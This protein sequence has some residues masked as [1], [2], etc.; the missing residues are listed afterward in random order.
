[1]STQGFS[2]MAP[3]RK[4][5]TLSDDLINEILVRLPVKSLVR[6]ESVSK[7]WLSLIKDPAFVNSQLLRAMTIETD[8]TLFVKR[9]SRNNHFAVLHVDSRQIVADLELP[10]PHGNVWRKVADPIDVPF[11]DFHVCVNGFLVGIGQ[12]DMMAFD[13]NKEV[14]NCAIKLPFISDEDDGEDNARVIEYNK[15][16]SV[17]TLM[18]IGRSG[19]EFDCR[20][21]E[22][23]MCG[24]WM[25]THAFVVVELRHHGRLC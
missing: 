12:D 23:I 6:F 25:M 1:M 20:F 7:T 4:N 5:P 14:L 22:K 16:I 17:I 21:Y 18:H 3:I 19:D 11:G 13:L 8:R 9:Y 2:P 24:C 15:C 10:Y